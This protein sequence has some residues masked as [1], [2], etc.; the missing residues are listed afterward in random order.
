MHV[1]DAILMGVTVTVREPMV[2]FS[3]DLEQNI[4]PRHASVVDV[5]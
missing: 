2:H 5:D 3:T 4:S 1:H